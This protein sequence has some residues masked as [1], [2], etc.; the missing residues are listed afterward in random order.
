[1]KTP[2][3]VS[4]FCIAVN[5]VLNLILMVPL[6]QGGLALATVISSYL[7]NLILLVILERAVGGVPWRD[8]LKYLAALLAI[9]LLPLYPAWLVCRFAA[10]LSDLVPLVRDFVPLCAAGAV[11][12]AI[13]LILAILFRMREVKILYSRFSGNRKKEV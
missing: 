5:L 7:N 2:M 13:F 1:M 10:P 4:V 6:R 8:M 9:S 11:F 12:V 3:Y